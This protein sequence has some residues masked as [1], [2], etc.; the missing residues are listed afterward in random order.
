MYVGHIQKIFLK[1]GLAYI[2]DV[3]KR[4]PLFLNGMEWNVWNWMEK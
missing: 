3:V 4:N 1:Q 2:L